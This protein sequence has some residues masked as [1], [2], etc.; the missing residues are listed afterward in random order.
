MHPVHLRERFLSRAQALHRIYGFHPCVCYVDA[1]EYSGRLAKV[2]VTID[3]KGHTITLCSIPEQ[4]LE[5]VEDGT[6]PVALKAP[7]VMVVISD[8]QTIPRNKVQGR[9]S[10]IPAKI[11]RHASHTLPSHAL[12]RWTPEHS[13]LRG[14]E[15]AREAARCFLLRDASAADSP[16]LNGVRERLLTYCYITHHYHLI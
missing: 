12:Q 1:V 2:G 3:S 15:M 13:T 9:L 14:N 5:F 10:T 11:L 8:S 7:Q 4:H 6:I 16:H